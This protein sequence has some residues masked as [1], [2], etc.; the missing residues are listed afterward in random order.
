[1]SLRVS[2]VVVAALA[3]ILTLSSL[4]SGSAQA[5]SITCDEAGNCVTRCSQTLG[6]G[7]FL[8]F[9]EGTEITVTDKDG[10]VRKFKCVN[11]DWVLQAGIQVGAGKFGNIGVASIGGVNGEL[12][13]E[14]CDDGD[15]TTTKRLFG[16]P[17]RLRKTGECNPTDIACPLN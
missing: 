15:C 8:E 10:V 13:Y 5:K 16:P 4:S 1:M 12:A 7:S 6:N 17:G 9:D 3:T 11:G 14:T 2:V